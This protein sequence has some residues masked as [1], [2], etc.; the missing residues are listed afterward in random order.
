M[1]ATWVEVNG[2]L[3]LHRSKYVVDLTASEAMRGWDAMNKVF[4]TKILPVISPICEMH[5]KRLQT[6]L[7]S[8]L[9]LAQFIVDTKVTIWV[10]FSY[11]H[12]KGWH[13]GTPAHHN[14]YLFG[15]C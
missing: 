15:S 1:W 12:A 11:M 3:E 7:L 2:L 13:K 14:M 6:S 10:G 5:I 8:F 4:A 9:L